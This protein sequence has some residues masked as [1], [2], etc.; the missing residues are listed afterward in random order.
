[1][2][3]TG[4]LMTGN[5]LVPLQ[6]HG[7]KTMSIGYLLRSFVLNSAVVDSQLQTQRMTV[8]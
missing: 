7:V 3:A 5:K 6:N 2:D 4:S 8:R 1:M